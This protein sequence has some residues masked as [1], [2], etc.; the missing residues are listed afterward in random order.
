M[1]ASWMLYAALVAALLTVA[2]VALE[3]VASARQWPIRFVWIGAVLLSLAWPVGS[4]ARGLMPAPTRRVTVL[5]FTIAVEPMR[6]IARG[7]I[8]P[9]R[10]VLIDRALVTLWCAFSALLLLRLSRGVVTLQQTRRVWTRGQID[11]T[12]VRLSDNVG[13]AVVGLRSMDVVVPQWIMTLDAPLRAIVL[14]HEEEHRTARDPYLLF[15]AAIAVVLMPW[16]LALWLQA[17]RLRLAIEMDCD[18]RVL[19]AHPSAERY[20]LL[21]LTIAQRRA[22]APT[23]FAPMLSEPTTHLERRIIAMR[24]TTRR[25]GKLTIYGGTAVALAALAVACS[26]QSGGRVFAAPI[27]SPIAARLLTKAAVPV[28]AREA[29]IALPPASS[30]APKAPRTEPRDIAQAQ[31]PNP[32]PLYPT[33]LRAAEVEGTVTVAWTTDANGA[34]N[35]DSFNVISKTHQLFANAVLNVL[36]QWR[37]TPN[38]QMRIPFVFVMS[39]LTGA[40]PFDVPVDAVVIVG[41]SPTPNAPVF[42]TVRAD[43]SAPPGPPTPVSDGQTY[44]EFQVEQSAKPEPGNVAPRYP[45]ALRQANVEGEVLMQFV[46][47]INGLPLPQ[48]FKVLKSSHELFSAAV[49]GALPDMRFYPALVGGQAVKQLVQMPF[50]FNLTR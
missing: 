48:T 35:M 29:V 28:V 36:P 34:P 7:S 49:V 17:R 25:L 44:F 11:G 38:S 22:V 19:R 18:V 21:M 24:T 6:I 16:N 43:P 37:S 8:A 42:V 32:K 47:D 45:D 12:A 14:R 5:P 39:N 50:L 15:A 9:D 26:L 30:A 40:R 41:N 4:V 1:I 20:G 46:V 3:R 10:A 23:L 13:P 2:A 31:T 27:A 33:L